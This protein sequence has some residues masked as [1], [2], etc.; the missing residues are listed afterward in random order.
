MRILLDLIRRAVDV[1]F[2][3]CIE[4]SGTGSYYVPAAGGAMKL[5]LTELQQH[6]TQFDQVGAVLLLPTYVTRTTSRELFLSYEMLVREATLLCQSD[7][8]CSII[9]LVVIQHE[10]SDWSLAVERLNALYS[11]LSQTDRVLHIGCLCE[12]RGKVRSL[13]K[14]FAVAAFARAPFVGWID[15]DIILSVGTMASLYQEISRDPQLFSVGS[16]KVPRPRRMVASKLLLKAKKAM[17]T[18]ATAYPHGCCMMLRLGNPVTLIPE[19]YC[20]DDGYFCFKL[21]VPDTSHP[22]RHMKIVEG[23]TCSHFVGGPAI[24]IFYRVRRSLL[25]AAVYLADFPDS[26][27]TFY[28]R[29]IMFRGLYPIARFDW[30]RGF[31]AGLCKNFLKGIYFTW[32]FATIAELYIRGKCGAP[33]VRIAWSPYSEHAKPS[34]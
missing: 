8:E 14:A 7:R 23:T 24:E 25:S 27:S 21:L 34:L 5:M 3:P 6:L 4:S 32:F 1:G 9:V 12:E 26:V 30:S 31:I 29:E 22:L 17:S 20:C 15:D 10:Q 11:Q 33:F 2:R 28:F 16:K 13:N 18:P 19:R